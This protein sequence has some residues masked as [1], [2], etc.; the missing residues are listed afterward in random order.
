MPAPTPKPAVRLIAAR[1]APAPGVARGSQRGS[2]S[3]F[4]QLPP[5]AMPSPSA[6]PQRMR[7]RMSSAAESDPRASTA[8]PTRA[9]NGAGT[10][11][12]RRPSRSESGP[13]TSRA[14]TMPRTYAKR[15]RSTTTGAKPCSSRY[16]TSSGVN[17]LPPQATANIAAATS[18]HVLR[19]TASVPVGRRPG[20]VAVAVT[21]VPLRVRAPHACARRAP[22]RMRRRPRRRRDPP[23]ACGRR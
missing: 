17:S 1:R 11:T 14:G 7:P 19:G 15:N 10:M 2:D 3:S 6:I 12:G 5:T 9:T 13:P 22:R 16:I 23:D 20:S 21:V 4:S 8:E 18:S